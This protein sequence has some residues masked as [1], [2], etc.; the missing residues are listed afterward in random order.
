M[1]RILFPLFLLF[2]LT[3]PAAMDPIRV[4]LGG[5]GVSSYAFPTEYDLNALTTPFSR[6]GYH[7]SNVSDAIDEAKSEA[8]GRARYALPLIMNGTVTNGN[9]ITYSNLTP[10]AHP[11][12]TVSEV[13]EEVTWSNT[14]LNV[15][16][17]LQFYRAVDGVET[18]LQTIQIR[19]DADGYAYVTGLNLTFSAGDRLKIRYV[20]QGDNVSDFVLVLFIR[21]T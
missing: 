13:L 2:T 17:D 18:L 9:Y 3:A 15:D 20:D 21:R 5:K 19:N 7:A 8:E 14:N 10:D 12:F 11:I 1:L 6:D 16:F 4:L